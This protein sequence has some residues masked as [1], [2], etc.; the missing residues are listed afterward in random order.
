[1][2][3]WDKRVVG[4]ALAGLLAWAS[5]SLW[6][7]AE[8]QAAQVSAGAAAASGI[9]VEIAA[10]LR[11]VAGSR[12]VQVTVTAFNDGQERVIWGQG[13]SSCQLEL[14]V[15]VEGAEYRGDVGRMCTADYGDQGLEPG[16]MRREV[17]DWAGE[18][19]RGGAVERLD[20]GV[21]RLRGGAGEFRSEPL[22]MEVRGH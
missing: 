22:E 8:G 19:L 5:G 16:G 4:V 2:T 3:C 12:P 11:V 17:F 15:E 9:R 14:W 20:P 1:M 21:Y 13:S 10:D 6:L 18:V 7:A